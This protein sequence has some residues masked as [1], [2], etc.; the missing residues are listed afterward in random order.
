MKRHFERSLVTIGLCAAAAACSSSDPGWT[1]IGADGGEPSSGASFGR[2]AAGGGKVYVAF[3][4]EN[5]GG[6][7]TVMQ[8]DGSS[9][10]LVGAAGFTSSAVDS[11]NLAIAVDS[12]GAPWVAYTTDDASGNSVITVEKFSGGNW[13]VQGAPG[14]APNS[15]TI[16]LAIADGAPYVAFVD[17]TGAGHVMTLGSAWSDLAGLGTSG[18]TSVMNPVLGTDGTTV[19][20]A[21][22]D[23]D[24]NDLVLAKLGGTTWSTLASTTVTMDDN[25]ASNVSVSN[26]TVWIGYANSTSGP[27]VMQLVGGNLQ[28]V[29]SL[30]SIA[31]G[32][33]IETV[34]A[35]VYNGVPYVAFDDET[36][37][38]DPDPRAATVKYWDGSKWTLY[39]GYPNPCDIEDTVLTTD[40][41]NGKLYLTYQD[42]N[43]FMAVDVH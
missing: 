2:I 8:S 15:A 26:G 27:V 1:G 42:C 5:A 23:A 29:G 24:A 4:D 7:L 31:N 14:F 37:D 20:V 35:T 12:S 28:S 30:G 25:W 32:D 6:Q 13:S 40:P 17:S 41:S 11:T 33:D 16:S 36:R 10:S 21:Y 39:A 34:S 9:W 43:G 18:A 3:S 38:G 19:Y 22:D